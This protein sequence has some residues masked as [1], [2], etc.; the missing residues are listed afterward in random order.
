MSTHFQGRRRYH[1][2]WLITDP[3][4]YHRDFG[5]DIMR[6]T[7]NDQTTDAAVWAARQSRMSKQF[8]A[9]GRLGHAVPADDLV[10]HTLLLPDVA[11]AHLADPHELWTLLQAR[12][13]GPHQHL[14]AGPTIWFPDAQNW[15]VPLRRVREFIQT[16]IVDRLLTPAHLFVH[17]PGKIGKTGDLH[18]HVMVCAQK[19]TGRG[20]SGFE[21]QLIQDGCQRSLYASW[22]AL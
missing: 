18:V 12:N 10:H 20:F 19:V 14:W 8:E 6:R 17:D 1:H 21:P 11:P 2:E 3:D 13:L 16:T 9:G 7:R 15:H 22:R 4:G 5:Y